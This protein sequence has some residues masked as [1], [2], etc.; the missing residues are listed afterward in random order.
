MSLL[1]NDPNDPGLR[2]LGADGQQEKYLVL[3]DEERA[4]GF[5]RPVRNKYIHLKC[6]VETRMGDTLSETYARDPFF[7]GG[8]FCV[9]CRT[10]F[11]LIDSEGKRAF[12]WSV[13]NT[14]V[15]E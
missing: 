13:D 7:Y 6:G 8:T 9:G 3:S 4:K 10:H 12:H 14:G 11:P 15:G 5:I 2:K 1:T